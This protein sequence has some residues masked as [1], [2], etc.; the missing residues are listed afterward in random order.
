MF[1]TKANINMGDMIKEN[2]KYGRQLIG[3]IRH[4]MVPKES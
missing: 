1:E 4:K 3:A 2:P